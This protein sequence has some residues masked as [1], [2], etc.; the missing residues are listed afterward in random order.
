MHIVNQQ[1][2]GEEINLVKI[3]YKLKFEYTHKTISDGYRITV[4]SASNW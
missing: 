1:K 3:E 4:F 2:T